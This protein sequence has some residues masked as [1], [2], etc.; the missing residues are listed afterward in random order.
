MTL[1]RQIK[2]NGKKCL[3][4]N[5]GKA[6][7]IVL[8]G[9]AI[10]L[11]FTVVET[12]LSFLVGLGGAQIGWGWYLPG[13]S[14]LSLVLT[15]IMAVGFLLIYAPLQIGIAG[16]YWSISSG[17]SEDILAVFAPFSSGKLFFRSLLLSL[18]LMVRKLFFGILYLIVPSAA[19]AAS[20]W[21]LRFGQ[22]EGALFVGTMG[23]VL[24]GVL[25][26]V[27]AAF[28][29]LFCQRYFLARYYLL[30]GETTAHQ[31]VK[32]SVQATAGHR[33]Q[34][35]VFQLSYLGWMALGVLLLPLLYV[36][37]YYEMSQLLYARF[38]MEQ[39]ERRNKL[40]VCEPSEAQVQE[41]CAKTREFQ[42]QDCQ[43]QEQ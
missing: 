27:A 37:P 23:V 34:L 20:I 19:L 26:L 18:G 16:W 12:I 5:W 41:D 17:R 8:L 35:F 24:G 11:L 2:Q 15:G 38:L 43:T 29:L 39:D 32:K 28:Y 22:F 6:I 3:Y 7:S 36:V 1:R 13:T 42:A 33:D 31:A 25:F 9:A 14:V 10:Y 21:C 40:A 4:N 30:D